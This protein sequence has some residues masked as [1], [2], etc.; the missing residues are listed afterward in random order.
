MPEAPWHGDEPTRDGLPAAPSGHAPR[1][2][3][4]TAV[5]LPSHPA[6]TN[7][8]SLLEWHREGPAG[9]FTGETW[10]DFVLGGVLGT[11]GMGQV[12]RARQLSLGRRVA[13]KVL[14]PHLA[15]DLHLLQRFTL[16]AST[17]ARLQSPHV[18]QVYAIGEHAGHHYYAMEFVPGTDLAAM[19][20]SGRTI[21]VPTAVD[22]VAQ[23]ARG[24]IEAHRL[25]VVHRDV[26][27]SNLIVSDSGVVKIADFGVVKVAGEQTLTGTGQAVGTPAYTSPEQARGGTVDS[28]ADLYSLGVVLYELVCG[29][30]PFIAE[31]PDA[32]LY[33][34]AFAEP[35]L[36]C[37]IA[38]AVTPAVQ[39][40][41]LRCLQK[42]PQQ[43][44]QTAEALVADL[45]AIASGSIPALPA[46][47]G[48]GA[49]DERR[50]HLPFTQ[51][52]A[53]ALGVAGAA[54]VVL[55]AG[56]A[57]WW[58][59]RQERLAAEQR[60]VAIE[61]ANVAAEQQRIAA[62]RLRQRLGNLLDVSATPPAHV[63][64]DLAELSRLAGAADDEVQR[65]QAKLTAVDRLR[66]ALTIPE[67]T[68]PGD[69][70]MILDRVTALESLVGA[71]DAQVRLWNDR[72]AARHAAIRRARDA[73]ER[74]DL[75]N[76]R[77]RAWLRLDEAV[78]ALAVLV[79]PDDPDVMRWRARVVGFTSGLDALRT[80][81]AGL[82][83]G[84]AL[85]APARAAV[86]Q[87]LTEI[88]A[89]LDEDDP[90]LG[91]WTAAVTG[92]AE[93][94]AA[95]R[96][97]IAARVGEHP[98]RIGPAAAASI[99]A[100]LGVVAG[101]AGD[102]DPQV[103]GWRAAITQG[104]QAAADARQRLA[105]L[106]RRPAE[107]ATAGERTAVV[108]ALATLRALGAEADP[109]AVAWLDRLDRTLAEANARL[110][111]PPDAALDEPQIK[112]LR[113]VLDRLVEAGHSDPARQAAVASRLDA[114]SANLIQRRSAAIAALRL[115]LAEL[116]D[117]VVLTPQRLTQAETDLA[118][119]A[120]LEAL[121]SATIPG[122]PTSALRT[123]RQRLA[124]LAGPP[125]PTWAT[126]DGRDRHGRWALAGIAGI[127]MRLR[128]IPPGVVRVGS[129]PDEPG[130]DDD[131]DPRRL[132]L[133]RGCWLAEVET[134]RALWSAVMGSD[135]SRDAATEPATT[136]V[137]RVS[138]QDA[139]DFMKKLNGHG[140][141][142]RLPREIEWEHACRAGHPGPWSVA[143]PAPGQPLVDQA[144]WWKGNADRPQPSRGRRANSL[145]LYD[146]H[147]NCAEWCADGHAQ[148]PADGTVMTD[149]MP[150][151]RKILRG[152]SA[153]DDARATR[154]ANR[155]P[156]EPRFRSVWV[157][158]RV[159]VEAQPTNR[160]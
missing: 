36:P 146:M 157:T 28:R 91:R 125:R 25:G 58:N 122:A 79:G 126:D 29:R 144:A 152:G 130:R 13:L 59:D 102:D 80:R 49:A 68:K 84:A 7:S 101:L 4:A 66:G 115:R 45:A 153:G 5:A 106:L 147:G 111:F 139:Q 143:D 15:H 159:A 74:A 69:W 94:A 34:H 112:A 140:L 104:A 81:L 123:A 117:L 22:W 32:L 24:L 46:L 8:V 63:A 138:W 23:A 154:A 150:G 3:G 2:G 50:R 129:P 27:P 43:R 82:D 40:V 134:P 145:G 67:P 141:P 128:W 127:S 131:E 33:Q 71:G 21:T 38:T 87:A 64:T 1:R 93:R 109:A 31:S 20:R 103:A 86:L 47:A 96:G 35:P 135:P 114:A 9:P 56:G 124:E 108:A 155:I 95:V 30:R 37:R 92:A 42:Q 17:A 11:G 57:W 119:L 148:W 90:D 39:S 116:D 120:A 160:P 48:T 12:Y 16:E 151:S 149:I 107:P 156:T 83:D 44:Y 55:V 99:A 142:A 110:D 132:I 73:G 70:P 136:P 19:L 78:S 85:S 98:D 18:V 105:E 52:H 121:E 6:S 61:Q 77:R 75:P 54:L 118:Q 26:K 76:L 158:V 72:L 10:G 51:R 89:Y 133:P 62:A 60:R 137:D 53:V 113:T 88:R 97:R 41:I 14:P 65:W 100:D